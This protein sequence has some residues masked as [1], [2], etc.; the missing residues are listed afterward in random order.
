MANEVD[1]RS[2]SEIGSTVTGARVVSVEWIC[3]GSRSSPTPSTLMT[4]VMDPTVK[5]WP[6]YGR[7]EEP[8]EKA[9]LFD[10]ETTRT[11][12][13]GAPTVDRISSA[14]LRGVSHEG[15]L[16]GRETCD[17]EQEGNRDTQVRQV[18]AVS[19]T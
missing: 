17:Q 14:V 6:G 18:Q 4:H 7:D 10:K 9:I 1:P 3:T 11:P 2:G 19:M 15:R 8:A 16:I 12:L 13:P 5:I